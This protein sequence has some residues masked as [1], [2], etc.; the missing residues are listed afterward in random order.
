MENRESNEALNLQE[1]LF[2]AKNLARSAGSLVLSMRQ[3]TLSVVQK[4]DEVS[5]IVTDADKASEK[6]ICR[7]LHKKF[8]THSI[9]GEEDQDNTQS[10]QSDYEWIIDPI[11][12]TLNFTNNRPFSV[13]I[14]LSCKGEPVLG[15]LYFPD[16]KTTFSAITGEGA[17]CND[18]SIERTTSKPLKE[19]R[20]GFDVSSN[21]DEIQELARFRQ[22]LK[23]SGATVSERMFC[24]TNAAREIMEGKI[25]AYVC[26]GGLTPYDLTAMMIILREAGCSAEGMFDP[27]I[28]LTNPKTPF[29]AGANS[30]LIAEIREVITNAEQ[31]RQYFHALAR[32]YS[33]EMRLLFLGGRLQE[34]KLNPKESWRNVVE[35]CLVQT[36]AAEALGELLGLPQDQRKAMAST[37]AIHDWSKRIEKEKTEKTEKADKF[38]EKTH[39]H[40][41]LLDATNIDVL[42]QLYLGQRT[43]FTWLQK[44]Q[45]YLDIITREHDIV[46]SEDRIT[47]V[48][49]APRS[50]GIGNKANG[51]YWQ[52]TRDLRDEV[53]KE[54][55]EQLKKKGHNI[56]SP[57]DIPLFIRAKIEEQWKAPPKKA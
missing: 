8:P 54:L 57:A 22:P 10:G 15:V 14:G 49:S 32:R 11:D 50:K 51:E 44:L 23:K 39:P 36:A 4:S 31:K 26:G 52:K 29:I 19:A 48:E 28:D 47:E 56:A 5:N 30:A 46:R 6:L 41:D 33:N 38:L 34:N 45:F 3:K 18:H 42:E 43:D 1:A 35:H 53:E 17:F 2:F 27:R 40:Q 55:F 21:G 9:R 24:S 20:V 16:D 37:S 12:G 25:D 7:E 13:S